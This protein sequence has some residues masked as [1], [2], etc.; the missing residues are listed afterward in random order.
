MASEIT[1]SFAFNRE[2]LKDWS[3]VINEL[4]FGDP[5]L[6]DLH[7]IE[8]GIKYNQQI[9]FAGRMG[10]MGKTVTGCTPNAVAGVALTEKTWTPV[11]IDFRLEHCSADVNAQD[12][13]IRA[14]SRMNPDFY[15]VIE[16]SNSVVGNFL[17]ASVIEGFNENLIRQAWFSD[18][19]AALTS[20]GGVFKVGTDLGY[21]NSYNGF[22]KQIFT[23]IPTSD[24]KYVAIAKNAGNSYANQALSSGDAIATLKAMYAKADSRL[25]DSG[26]A[27][28]YVTR[29]LWDG[30]LNDL[31]SIQNSGAGNTII[32][33]NGQVSL[34][35]RG[36][37]VQKVEIWDRSIAAYQDNGTKWN[38]PHRAVLSTPMNLKIG[39]LAS[40]DFGTLEAFY[41]Q[42]HKVN[43]ID[44][45]YTI[46]AKHLEK[47]MTVA[48]Y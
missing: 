30:Y 17:V 13:L 22:F 45:V 19:A 48:A 47:Y 3:K 6:N 16:G 12:K 46:D 34:T 28:F 33:E 37:P 1:S 20:G 35:Y 40:D 11:D 27:K 31:E 32:N 10:L 2:E 7:D 5:T 29:T 18:T 36:I 14:M 25:L 15:N 9:V 38:L 42:Y 43:V 44:G 4:T 8:Q 24:A 23:E 21:F 41:D 26:N 39:T